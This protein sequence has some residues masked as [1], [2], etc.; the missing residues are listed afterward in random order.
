M[1]VNFVKIGAVKATLLMDVNQFGIWD[2]N[3]MLLRMS[4]TK[5]GTRKGILFLWA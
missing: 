1:I 2:L 3:I 4:F 5:T